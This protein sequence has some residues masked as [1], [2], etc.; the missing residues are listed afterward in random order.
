M[1]RYQGDPAIKISQSG[2]TMEFRGG[3]PV[4]DRG[5]ENY[6]LIS[7][8]TLPGWWGNALTTDANK[9][10]GSNFSAPRTHVDVRT[11]NEY[12]DDARSALRAMTDSGLASKVDVAVTNPRADQI[13]TTIKIYP[14][15]QDART[16]VFTKNGLAWIA[17][18]TDPAHER[19]T[20]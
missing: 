2:A 9:K 4:R 8:L 1:S 10:I 18:A 14:P 7:L 11:V 5:L 15:G 12:G 19:F 6:V 13:N 17:Q 16:L 3:E 20:I